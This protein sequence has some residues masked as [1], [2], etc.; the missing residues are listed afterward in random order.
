M[1]GLWTE[2]QIHFNRN[3]LRFSFLKIKPNYIFGNS[4]CLRYFV[5][6]FYWS[7]LW[8]FGFIFPEF[9]SL[10]CL[11]SFFIEE[12]MKF[13]CNIEYF[14]LG[15]S[16]TKILAIKRFCMTNCIFFWIYKNSIHPKIAKSNS[17]VSTIIE[18]LQYS[19]RLIKM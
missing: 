9:L 16:N 3:L 7:S 11:Q 8:N 10:G 6:K 5:T 13:S 17:A 2:S 19:S 12:F 4:S 14:L 1:R 15:L 18:F